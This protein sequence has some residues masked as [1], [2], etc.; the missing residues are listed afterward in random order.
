MYIAE[1]SSLA[2]ALCWSFGGLIATGP[3]R[4]LGAV[5]FN[6]LRMILVFVMLS[7][8]ALATGGW[9]TLKQ[10]HW[11][12]LVASA[13]VG[14]FMGD[15]AFYAALRRLGPRRTGILFA[16]NAP[17]AAL[18]GFLFLGERLPTS[19]TAGCALIMAGVFLAVFHGTTS[20]QRHTFEEVRGSLSTGVALGLFAA[21]CQAVSLVI[22]RPVLASGVDPVA[23]SALRVGTAALALS[24]VL[25]IRAPALRSGAPLTKRLVAQVALSGLVGMALGMTFL[26][27][28][29]AHG[30]AGLV[31]TL[32]ATSPILIL[33]VLWV[34]TRERPAPGAWVGAAL[35]V[36]GAGCIFN[37]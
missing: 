28:A 26:L 11:A 1:L 17:M 14:I 6:R 30:P 33:P 12:V 24:V 9:W 20:V 23:A 22:V 5:T 3:V 25:L 7:S 31:S 8:A 16:T 21:L 32:S 4:A 35:A 2:A 19:T 36:V 29:L 15:T 18:L 13:M 37:P 10:S 27:A 34:A